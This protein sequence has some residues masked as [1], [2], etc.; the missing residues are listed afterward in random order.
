M[1]L[2]CIV[3]SAEDVLAEPPDDGTPYTNIGGGGGES[4]VRDRENR[5][6]AANVRRVSV[7]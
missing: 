7:V 6:P 1:L 5:R 3:M 4:R 2:H